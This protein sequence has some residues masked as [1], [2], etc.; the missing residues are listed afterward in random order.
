MGFALYSQHVLLLDPCPLCV[1][2]RVAVIGLG[3]VF[4]IAALHLCGLATL[5][6]TP[7]PM[8]FL[9]EILGRPANERAVMILV[10]GYPAADATVPLIGKKPLDEIA[11]F[12]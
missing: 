4:L 11:S 6:H 10:A 2:Q 7:S 8:K 3:V 5:T 1:L 12:F 9:R